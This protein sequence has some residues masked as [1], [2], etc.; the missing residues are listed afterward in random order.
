MA[1]SW[2]ADPVAPS[3]APTVS[4]PPAARQKFLDENPSIV[5]WPPQFSWRELCCWLKCSEFPQKSALWKRTGWSEWP[6]RYGSNFVCQWFIHRLLNPAA[7]SFSSHPNRC[8]SPSMAGE[9]LPPKPKKAV[10]HLRWRRA[11]FWHWQRDWAHNSHAIPSWHPLIHNSDTLLREVKL[12]PR[13]AGLWAAFFHHRIKWSV[14]RH[15]KGPHWTWFGWIGSTHSPWLEDPE[16]TCCF[17]RRHQSPCP[18]CG[19]IECS[20]VQEDVIPMNTGKVTRAT[21]STSQYQHPA[22]RGW[23]INIRPPTDNAQCILLKCWWHCWSINS[24]SACVGWQ[25]ML[26]ASYSMEGGDQHPRMEPSFTVDARHNVWYAAKS[27]CSWLI[28]R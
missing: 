9:Q 1:T 6:P 18:F 14:H 24:S 27:F 5:R 3:L 2:N 20:D 22:S 26:L 4:K 8:W 17:Q 12:N 25:N 23:L 19:V 11:H 16:A 21:I 28:S 15:G 7:H 13:S 10:W